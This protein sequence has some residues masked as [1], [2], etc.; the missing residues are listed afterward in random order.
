MA[1]QLLKVSENK[2]FIAN[3]DGT[4]FF[5]LGDT[6]WE[7]FHRLDRSE[8]VEYLT[9]RTELG[10]NVIQA[11]TL[12]EFE[13]LTTDN[14]YGRLPLLKNDQG[15]Y[16]PTL[17][18]LT[19]DYS[20]WDH[21]DYILDKAEELGLYVGLL[22][23]W[24]DKYNQKWGKGP[25]VF[26]PNN[27]RVYGKWLGERYKDRIN[28]IWI[29]GGDRPLESDEHYEVIRAMADGIIE[30]DGG[31]HLITFHPPGCNSSSSFV[32]EDNWL[33]FNMIQSS[34]SLDIYNF[35][36]IEADYSLS[37]V[38]PVLDGEP[39][40]E[41]HPINFKPENGFYRDMEARRAGYWGVFAGG[42]GHTY[43]HHSIWSMTT[44][45]GDY[46]IMT[47]RE[48]LKR[49]G[50]SQVQYLRRLMESRPFFDRK[51]DQ[52]LIVEQYPDTGHIQATRGLD[53]AFIY[54]PDGRN[55]KVQMGIINGV[56]IKAHWYDPRNGD[57]H[58][59]GEFY[60]SGVLSFNPPTNGFGNDWVLVLDDAAADR[61]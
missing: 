53:Y 52:S 40:Y 48:A 45:P 46:F 29:L 58:F 25:V 1:L 5:W 36:R 20:Y 50:G 38:K 49:P 32:H 15:I 10:Y 9:N 14:R 19:G 60:N 57:T 61:A 12:A 37:P 27:A 33:S 39:C 42:F 43:G 35:K 18:D 11:V 13:G 56:N 17:P 55:V 3:G 21:V 47:W 2:R 41:D 23:T 51:P 34:H 44:E 31:N 26:N 7:L 54:S 4:P 30:G 24:G 22:P 6:A 16:D 28:I 59:I 8:A